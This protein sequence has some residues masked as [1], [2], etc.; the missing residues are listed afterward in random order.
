MTDLKKCLHDST[1]IEL[2]KE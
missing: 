1:Y 2:L